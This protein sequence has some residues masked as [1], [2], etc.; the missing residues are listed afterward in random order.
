MMLKFYIDD[1][2]FYFKFLLFT[3][4]QSEEKDSENPW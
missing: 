1:L 2:H 4:C 3:G